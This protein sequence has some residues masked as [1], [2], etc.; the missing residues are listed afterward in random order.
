MVWVFDNL[1]DAISVFGQVAGNDP[2][3]LLLL[4][5]SVVVLLVSV[6]VFG[7]LALGGVLSWGGRLI[8]Y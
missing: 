1:V 2:I 4:L 5:S 8:G 7:Y 3:S 6:G